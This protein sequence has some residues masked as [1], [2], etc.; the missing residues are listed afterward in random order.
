MADAA[1]SSWGRLKRRR[2]ASQTM[3]AIRTGLPSH[4]GPTLLAY[5]NGRSYGDSC[6]NDQGLLI[7]QR[8]NRRILD[9]DPVTGLIRCEA[10]VLLKDIL[11]CAIPHGF[12]LPV[13]PGTQY[14]TVGGA[15]ANDVHGKNHHRTGSFGAHVEYFSLWQSDGTVV[16][17]TPGENTAYFEAT[18]GGMG[19][20]GVII[21]AVIRLKPVTS[22]DLMQKTIRFRNLSEYFDLIDAVDA[23]HEYSVAWVDQLARGSTFG[24]GLLM[25]ANHSETARLKASRR[26]FKPGIPL[27]PPFNVLNRLTL[28]AFNALYYNRA[29]QGERHIAWQSYFYPLDGIKNWNRLYGPR[30][31]YQHQSVYPLASAEATTKALLTCAQD[32]GEASFLTVLKRF[33]PK[34]SSGLLSF[35][36]E[37]V[38]LT[39]DFANG[40]KRTRAMLNDLDAIV[41]AA[42][43][44]VN[45]YKDARMSAETFACSFS[46]WRA[47]EEKRDPNIMSDFWQRTAMKLGHGDMRTDRPSTTLEVSAHP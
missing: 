30:G 5:G 47:L 4:E 10:G 28:K 2:R 46:H 27:T 33:G 34:R 9:F 6:H 17:C 42:G 13:T 23:D 26:A 22:P 25:A 37:G 32:Q 19:L 41:V 8:D 31:L 40:G 35:A 20:T 43:G 7:D 29:H 36:R 16:E 21:E 39:L 44:A 3:N 1:F 12:F 14:V 38:T 18:I 15:I 45:P 11:S 24:R